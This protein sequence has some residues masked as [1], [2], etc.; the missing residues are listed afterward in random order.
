MLWTF[1]LT[2]F[3]LLI[4]LTNK[5]QNIRPMTT[6]IDNLLEFFDENC[7]KKTLNWTGAH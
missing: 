5:A 1:S 2:L 6:P 4:I 3:F 7:K